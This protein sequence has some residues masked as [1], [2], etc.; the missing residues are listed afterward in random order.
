MARYGYKKVQ[1]VYKKLC[2]IS[3]EALEQEQFTKLKD[4]VSFHYERNAVYRAMLQKSGV[5]PDQ[6]NTSEDLQLLPVITASMI[7][8]HGDD[9]FTCP[10]ETITYL[11]TSGSTGKAKIIPVTA[12]GKTQLTFNDALTAY[13]LGVRQGPI[14]CTY[15]CGPWPSAFFAQ[16]GG[17]LLAATIR[18]DMGLPIEWHI[19]VIQRFRPKV[20]MASPSYISFFAT[21]L[22]KRGIVLADLGVEL[23]KLAGEPLSSGLRQKIAA[24]FQARV[25]DLY[26]SAEIGAASVE[27]PQIAGTGY[28]H[29]LAHE[30]LYEVQKIGS[31]GV[32]CEPGE[33]G[34]LLVTAL[35]RRSIPIIR[36]NTKDIVM[37]ADP[38]KRCECGLRLP[39]SSHILGRSDDML[40]YGGA[41]VYPEMFYM[42]LAD[43]GL[44]DKFQ[45]LV[46]TSEETLQDTLVIRVE[47]GA[48][49]DMPERRN[50]SGLLEQKLRQLSSELDY[51]FRRELVKPIRVD[52][53]EYGTLYSGSAKLQRFRDMRTH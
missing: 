32:L 39:M 50:L 52:M 11:H 20:I 17:E 6:I 23:I 25:M 41:N 5:R 31:D 14:Y 26:G 13:I 43:L 36:Y 34:E 44:D 42:A 8:T 22:Q 33:Q 48:H 27:C 21:E 15:P 35:F 53:L 29:Y 4:I 3:Q 1:R 47:K 40:T 46:E 12:K 2:S 7:T 49:A 37:L 30:I 9:F 45:V 38:A 10:E 24:L 16:Q 51:V 18:A 28:H 19:P